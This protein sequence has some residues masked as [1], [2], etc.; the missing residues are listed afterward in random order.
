MQIRKSEKAQKRKEANAPKTQAKKELRIGWLEISA[1]ILLSIFIFVYT[2]QI[3]Q[4]FGDYSYVG[5]FLLSLI[6]SASVFFPTAPLQ[7]AIISIGAVLNPILVGIC[8]GVGSAI[9]ELTGFV[10]GSGSR[11]V[12][13]TKDKYAKYLIRLQK[14]MIK[15][16]AGLAIFLLA[17]VPN[18][19][20]DFAG[21]LAGLLKMKWWEFLLW[22][23]AGRILRYT[24]IAYFGL[25]MHTMI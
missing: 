6:A 14:G 23:G 20:F 17:L 15:K 3:V 22:A 16:H 11:R 2:P 13:Q 5:I 1:A 8:A 9:G 7:F 24:L 19:F 4:M 25:W 18:P 21:I 10:I 12:L